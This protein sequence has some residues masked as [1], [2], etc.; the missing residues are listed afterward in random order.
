MFSFNHEQGACSTCKGLGYSIVCDVE[1]LISN[2]ELA[3]GK[4]AMSGHKTGKFYDDYFGQYIAILYE[5]G[6][7]HLIDFTLPWNRLSSDAQDIAMFGTGKQTYDVDWKYK[8]KNVEGSHKFTTKWLGFLKLV[9]EEFERKHADKRGD[10]MLPIMKQE[11]CKICKGTRLRKESTSVKFAEKNIAELSALSVKQSITFFNSLENIIKDKGTLKIIKN[12]R[13]EVLNRLN[14]L[15]DIGLSYLTID[16]RSNTLSGGESRRMQLAGQL[17]SGLTGITYILDE[18]SIGLHYKDTKKLINLLYKLRN[19]GNTVIVVEHDADIIS[20]ADNI[21]DL[22][23][24][25]GSGGGEIVAEGSLQNIISASGSL[26]GKYLRNP[27]SLNFKKRRLSKGI[28]IENAYANNLKNINVEFPS[29]GITAITGVSG[30]GKSSLLFDVLYKSANAKRPVNCKNIKGFEKFS[31]II[32]V[33][34]NLPGKSASSNTATYIGFFDII[35][36]LFAEEESAKEQGIKKTDFSFNTKGGRCEN[37]KGTGKI[38]TAMDFLAD[39]YTICEECKGK[40]FQNKVL[41]IKYKD[42]SIFEVMH[43]TV[44]EAS[45][46]FS[47]NKK[48]LSYFYVLSQIG[49]DYLT[50]GQSLNTF[51]G[52]ELQRIKLALSLSEKQHGKTL[53]LFDEPTTGLHFKDTETLLKLM[54]YM[55]DKGNSII[56]TEHNR[57]IIRYADYVIELGP[58]GGNNGGHLISSDDLSQFFI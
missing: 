32:Y 28:L 6:K 21:I 25:A 53:Y 41:N 3:F 36:T 44:S 38:K 56:L 20:C 34:Q 37:C 7:T 24:G 51:S 17:V 55:C 22:G 2:P 19:E 39:V 47:D 10:S 29:G 58:E 42:K 1:K 31:K 33:N 26:T 16:R 48:L 8:R 12:I 50:L 27:I 46:F 49:L 23:P 15:N 9:N 18:P 52:G 14:V 4:G 45:K 54:D 40:R 5:V 30:S 11:Q 43:L 13:V 57:D 35:R